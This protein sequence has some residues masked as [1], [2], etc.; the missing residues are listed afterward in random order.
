MQSCVHRCEQVCSTCVFPFAVAM[1]R[2]T[3]AAKD[4]RL[5][6]GRRQKSW[7]RSM[8]A[9]GPQ[10]LLLFLGTFVG[11]L[12]ILARFF[13]RPKGIVVRLHSLAIFVDGA[14]AL[15]GHVEDLAQL[16]AAPD[17]SPARFAV[18]V[19]SFAI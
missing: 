14:F 19:D 4:S 11:L 2:Q 17:F 1:L 6:D 16:N 15:A 10:W 18:A 13:E 9:S 7:G 3:L 8:D 12:Q 5:L